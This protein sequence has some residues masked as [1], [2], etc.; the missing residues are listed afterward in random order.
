MSLFDLIYNLVPVRLSDPL[1]QFQ[2]MGNLVE[3]VP[4]PLIA[5]FLVFYGSQDRMV[6]WEHLVIKIIY[7]GLLVAGIGYILLVPLGVVSTVQLYRGDDNQV[8]QQIAQGT[9]QID[10]IKKQLAGINTEAQMRD[11]LNRI[12]GLPPDV[13]EFQ[14]LEESKRRLTDFISK[15]TADSI[16]QI[17]QDYFGRR[18]QL[19][20]QSVTWILTSV[21]SGVLFIWIWKIMTERA[22]LKKMD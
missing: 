18:F 13:R 11:V 6:K 1:W 5:L 4:V 20:K 9:N 2:T 19:L 12:Q 22:F 14:G 16:K 7:W 21:L 8:R 17:N 3:K 10:L 15:S